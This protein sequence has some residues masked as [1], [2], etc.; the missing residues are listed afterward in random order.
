MPSAP[1]RACH[2]CGLVQHLPPLPKK[3][4]A[5]CAR[6]RTRLAPTRLRRNRELAAGAAWAALV[7]YPAAMLLPALEIERFGHLHR[8]NI[9]NGTLELLA[10]GDFLVGLIVLVCSVIL[11]F[12]KLLGLIILSGPHFLLAD[13]HKAVTYRLIEITGRWGMVDVLV[14]ALLVA[15]LKLGDVVSVAPGPGIA[16]F[17][18]MVFLN[19]VASASFDPHAL[20]DNEPSA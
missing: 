3:S 16:A 15:F 8:S 4:L 9:L 10:G 19:L 20:W 17:T 1:V 18:A 11:P 14:V 6:C 7:L 2:S 12:L 5:T 13:H